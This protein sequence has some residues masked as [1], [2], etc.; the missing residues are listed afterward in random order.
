MNDYLDT[1]RAQLAAAAQDLD[2]LREQPQPVA[3]LVTIAE[4]KVAALTG[5]IE[6]EERR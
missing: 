6:R 2:R 1:L 3:L 4:Q 5:M